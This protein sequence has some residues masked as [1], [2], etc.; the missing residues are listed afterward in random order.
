MTGDAAIPKGQETWTCKLLHLTFALALAFV[1]GVLAG[2]GGSASKGTPPTNLV[3]AQAAIKAMVGQAIAA[4]APTVTGNV[5]AYAVSPALPAGLTLNIATGAISGTPTAVSAQTSY[6]VTANNASGS[7]ATVVQITVNPLPPS[8]LVYPQSTISAVVAQAVPVDLPVVTGMVSS[9]A[10]SPALPAGLNL[11]PATGAI[12]GTPTTV[13]A[14]ASYT[15]SASNLSGSTTA[16]VQ[17]TVGPPAPSSLLYGVTAISATV[18]QAVPPDVPTV[19]GSVSSYTI[20]PALPAGLSFNSSTG[21]ISGT[22]TAASPQT[23]YTV[24]ANN[25]SGSTT[26]VVQVTV[27]PFNVFALVDLG[28][29]D[30]M[31]QMRSNATRLLSQDVSGHWALWD[32]ASRKEL[33]SGDATINSRG[34]PFPSDMAGTIFM[35]GTAGAIEVHSNVDGSLITTVTAPSLNPVPSGVKAW[36]KLATDGSYIAAGSSSGLFVW[37][38]TDGH[39]LFSLTGDYS[40]ASAYAAAGQ[41]EIG[42]GP[43]GNVIERD[44]VP[45]GVTSRGPAFS[46]TFNAWFSDGSHFMTNSGDLSSPGATPSFYVWVYD[47]GAVLQNSLVL[48]DLALNGYGN[49]FW[50]VP[51]NS[52]ALTLY[53]VGSSSNTPVGTFG[54]GTDGFVV[55]FG[56]T[57]GLVPYAPDTVSILDISGTTP[58]LTHVA[59]SATGETTFAA[60]SPT[61]WVMGDYQGVVVDGPSLATT[62]QYFGYGNA[63]SM[64]GSPGSVAIATAI[65]KVLVYSPNSGALL[66]TLDLSTLKVVTSSDGAVLAAKPRSGNSLDIYTLPAGSVTY[67][68]ASSLPSGAATTSLLDYTMSN[69]GN[70]VGR[71]LG[72]PNGGTRNYA[73]QVTPLT[74]SPVLWSDT[75]PSG[76]SGSP[77]LHLSPNG[78]LVAASLG[79]GDMSS[80]S[81]TGIYRNGTLVTTVSGVGVGWIDDHRLLVDTF[82]AR[83][84][85]FPALYTGTVIYDDTGAQLASVNNLPQID[86]FWMLDADTLYVPSLYSTYSLSTGKLIRSETLPHPSTTYPPYGGASTVCGRYVVFTSRT[87]VLVDLF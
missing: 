79:G 70:A 75:P 54:A 68:L 37:S 73:R 77:G 38:T 19:S 47:S 84:G 23:S 15:I 52:G 2:C 66:S 22:P 17:I 86:G 61:R 29:A 10:V 59:Y 21:A 62:P 30:A 40:Q 1:I 44:S 81:L 64:A 60:T 69:S 3:Y 46:G 63:F 85:L 51:E 72:T 14:Q 11:D 31:Y 34:I 24:T 28:H 65:G 9:Y 41:I 80:S 57:I 53:R 20:S 45:S 78:L 49:W 7:T 76:F 35:V 48:G 43:A 74:G 50:V 26:A 58:V 12:S 55:P 25:V 6:T 18:A 39:L 36:S 56:S 8:N 67:Q 83:D 4:D 87:R 32:Y 5:S 13:S 82:S 27:N 42:G 16:V 33:A 71:L